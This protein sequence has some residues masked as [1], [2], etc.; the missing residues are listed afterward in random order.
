MKKYEVEKEREY[1]AR[2]ARLLFK[3][4][5]E[6]RERCAK[7][8]DALAVA[9]KIAGGKEWTPAQREAGT[10]TAAWLRDEIRK[11]E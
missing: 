9:F 8:C 11:G 6:E 7:V 1:L 3:A 10:I 5:I 2:L 4:V